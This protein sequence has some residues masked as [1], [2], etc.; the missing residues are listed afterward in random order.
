MARTPSFV[1]SCFLELG[2]FNAQY[3]VARR[4]TK[5]GNKTKGRKSRARAA[6]NWGRKGAL[7]MLLL[8]EDPIRD[9]TTQL[10]TPRRTQPAKTNLALFVNVN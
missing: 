4:K 6:T 7:C 1:L 10:T 5:K 8:T 2:G 3:M 9:S